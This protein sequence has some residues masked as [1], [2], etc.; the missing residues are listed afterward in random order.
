M[1]KSLSLHHGKK[2]KATKE[3]RGTL[4]GNIEKGSVKKKGEIDTARVRGR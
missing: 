3:K 2:Q 4:C 1:S